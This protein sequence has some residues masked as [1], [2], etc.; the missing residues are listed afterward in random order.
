MY[1][2][3][4]DNKSKASQRPLASIDNIQLQQKFEHLEQKCLNLYTL[5]H[6]PNFFMIKKTI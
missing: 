3:F 5:A 2:K 1:F 6:K 4:E